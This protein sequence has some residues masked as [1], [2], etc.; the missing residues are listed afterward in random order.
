MRLKLFEV[1]FYDKKSILVKAQNIEEA[2]LKITEPLWSVYKI[3]QVDYR[4]EVSS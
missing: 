1:T 3:E 4:A 2:W